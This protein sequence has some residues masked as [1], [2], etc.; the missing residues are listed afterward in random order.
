MAKVENVTQNQLHQTVNPVQIQQAQSAQQTVQQLI[1]PAS[2]EAVITTTIQ[3]VTKPT[4]EVIIN[5]INNCIAPP[6]L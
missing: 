1:P 2:T 3:D 5:K 4:N 6:G